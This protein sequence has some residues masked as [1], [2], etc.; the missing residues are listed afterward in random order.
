MTLE[1]MKRARL[2]HLINPPVIVG[3]NTV[4]LSPPLNSI[5]AYMQYLEDHKEDYHRFFHG[6]LDG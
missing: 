4:V 1:E 3:P 2:D 6:D 5:A